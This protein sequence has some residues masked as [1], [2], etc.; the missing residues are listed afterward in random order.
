M[1]TEDS[2]YVPFPGVTLRQVRPMS[3]IDLITSYKKGV[4][5]CNRKCACRLWVNCRYYNNRKWKESRENEDEHMEAIW[6]YYNVI[7]RISYDM[8]IANMNG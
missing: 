8:P 5:G 4:T 6:E 2:M 7:F 1:T 3:T